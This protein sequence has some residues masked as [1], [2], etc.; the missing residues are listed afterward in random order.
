MRATAAHLPG[1]AKVSMTAAQF[2]RLADLISGLSEA[3]PTAEPDP[4][5]FRDDP[6]WV[7]LELFRQA[8]AEAQQW[9]DECS[10]LRAGGTEPDDRF[11][12]GW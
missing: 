7:P 8:R 4:D 12:F 10:R 6:H 2:S 9:K 3:V 1:G 5:S 11:N